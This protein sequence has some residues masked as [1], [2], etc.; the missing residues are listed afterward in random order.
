MED[1]IRTY[2]LVKSPD[3]DLDNTE[4]TIYVTCKED[5]YLYLKYLVNNN[6]TSEKIFIDYL[7][8]YA[9]HKALDGTLYFITKD[10][11]KY[12]KKH[13]RKIREFMRLFVNEW[14]RKYLVRTKIILNK[15]EEKIKRTAMDK[16]NSVFLEEIF[17]NEEL[18]EVSEYIINIL[19]KNGERCF[20]N[21]LCEQLIKARIQ[22][23]ES[24][25][26]IDKIQLMQSLGIEA[27]RMTYVVGPLI[28]VL[29]NLKPKVREW[30]SG[31]QAPSDSRKVY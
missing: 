7:T 6:L 9:L 12:I 15:D 2:L 10:D 18:N 24:T 30:R 31:M 8:K 5:I 19:L 14:W 4:R 16:T 27:K 22:Q 23:T 17:T 29:P 1:L 21:I 20:L 28:F 25:K 3:L 11:A 13:E 26:K